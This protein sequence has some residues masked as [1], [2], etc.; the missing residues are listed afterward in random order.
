[1]CICPAGFQ[2]QNVDKMHVPRPQDQN[3]VIKQSAAASSHLPTQASPL[4]YITRKNTGYLLPFSL[5]DDPSP[6]GALPLSP[7]GYLLP[8]S[9]S[10][11]WLLCIL[12]VPGPSLPLEP[13]LWDLWAYTLLYSKHSSYGSIFR[14]LL[15]RFLPSSLLIAIHRFECT[16]ENNISQKYLYVHTYSMCVCTEVY[17]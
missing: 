10:K 11:I 17:R 2:I 6:I 8:L 1:M 9:P 13:H 5:I 15:F 7:L 3:L 14:C 4:N 12:L 16:H